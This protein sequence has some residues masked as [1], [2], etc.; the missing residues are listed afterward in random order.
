MIRRL[1]RGFA[2]A[3]TVAAASAAQADD[4]AQVVLLAPCGHQ[5]SYLDGGSVWRRNA[6]RD[7]G[8]GVVSQL[9]KVTGDFAHREIELVDC[10]AGEELFVTDVRVSNGMATLPQGTPFQ[11]RMAR[12]RAA[13]RLR[14]L[15]AAGTGFGDSGQ[16]IGIPVDWRSNV[17]AACACEHFYPGSSGLPADIIPAP[18][19][20]HEVLNPT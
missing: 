8:G 19:Q 2:V 10:R 13:G 4:N 1:A 6:A 7:E 16:Q 17:N 9:T 14:D 15:G 11:D 18:D 12:L 20:V 5:L 3:A